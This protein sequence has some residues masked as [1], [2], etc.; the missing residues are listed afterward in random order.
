MSED[1]EYIVF[2]YLVPKLPK[3]VRRKLGKEKAWGTFNSNNIIEIDE[4][5]KGKKELIIYTHEILHF[6]FPNLSENEIIR[7]S[8]TLSEFLWKH[9]YRKVDN[10][11]K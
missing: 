10:D 3:V 9:H 7:S 6:I 11:E 8:E 2:D 1:V 5:L 4:R